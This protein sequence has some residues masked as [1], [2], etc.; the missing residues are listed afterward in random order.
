M[1]LLERKDPK[2]TPL[3]SQVLEL[4]RN[5][6]FNGPEIAQKLNKSISQVAN[7]LEMARSKE[8][9]LKLIS[10]K[11]S[12]GFTPLYVAR[13]FDKTIYSTKPLNKLK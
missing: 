1:R 4:F 3:E 12:Y 10:E 6:N 9:L 2:L 8:S 11:K 5:G 13:H 7:C